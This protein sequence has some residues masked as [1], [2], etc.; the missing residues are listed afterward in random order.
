MSKTNGHN[1]EKTEIL[2]LNEDIKSGV[3]RKKS[4]IIFVIFFTF[5]SFFFLYA[6]V[7]DNLVNTPQRVFNTFMKTI[8]DKLLRF[9]DINGYYDINFD[10][11]TNSKNYDIIND[12][13]YKIL[14][15]KNK[16]DMDFEFLM[17][18]DKDYNYN[19]FIRNH[20]LFHMFSGYDDI[21]KYGEVSSSL[22]LKIDDLNYLT[23]KMIYFIK[24]GES[25]DNFSREN[26]VKDFKNKKISMV[27]NTYKIDDKEFYRL[28]KVLGD[29]LYNDYRSM[30]ILS[31]V[32][33]VSK[34]EFK[35]IIDDICINDFE[36]EL[37]I[38]IYTKGSKFYGFDF[39]YNDKS[40]DESL[41]INFEYLNNNHFSK[42][43]KVDIYGSS[44]YTFDLIIN[45]T[46][47]RLHDINNF[48]VLSDE[49]FSFLVTDFISSMDNTPIGAV[50]NDLINE[51]SII[52]YYY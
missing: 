48:R 7:R 25:K 41:K 26:V 30:N 39:T 10:I 47:K 33:A 49:E 2:S 35:N 16:N 40:I 34:E 46:D 19:L 23:K 4:I 8:S 15:G 9:S 6:F 17:D 51:D 32:F 42:K 14:F 20:N 31:N 28:S 1:F 18:G 38:N 52:E 24:C 12:Y 13:K 21:I 11:K 43:I 5:F 29:G 50:L 22:N 45:K 3:K 37:F 36:G 44:H 27:K